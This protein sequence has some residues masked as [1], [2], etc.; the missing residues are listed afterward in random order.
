[1]ADLNIDGLLDNFTGKT[2]V[3]PEPVPF[4]QFDKQ[5]ED[6]EDFEEGKAA[7][8]MRS[9]HDGHICPLNWC[10]L[11]KPRCIC[12]LRGFMVNRKTQT[13][14]DQQPMKQ[15]KDH[16]VLPDL[17][18]R[19]ILSGI[20][21]IADVEKPQDFDQMLEFRNKELERKNLQP[22]VKQLDLSDPEVLFRKRSDRTATIITSMGQTNCSP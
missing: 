17:N 12:H 15:E 21:E 2:N 4:L 18:A 1:M 3:Q 16:V 14:G 22:K 5:E 20:S 6:D 8:S 9:P 11:A 7:Y 10:K 13:D 19:K